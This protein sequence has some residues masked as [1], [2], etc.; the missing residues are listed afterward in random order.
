MVGH[1]QVMQIWNKSAK[2]HKFKNRGDESSVRIK[3]SEITLVTLPFW[4]ILY[5]CQA[6]L[7]SIAISRTLM[8]TYPECSDQVQWAQRNAKPSF[9]IRAITDIQNSIWP[10]FE[11][12][13]LQFL[14][15]HGRYISNG[16]C[17]VQF[18]CRIFLMYTNPG[19]ISLVPYKQGRI[20]GASFSKTTF[21]ENNARKWAAASRS[22]VKFLVSVT[23]TATCV[24]LYL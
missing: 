16:P 12:K 3:N 13:Y 14:V 20:S 4:T 2:S 8:V 24:N 15:S 21:H 1:R 9:Q 17:N 22:K 11:Y 10:H 5:A 7:R 23:I 6:Y 18:L 19:R